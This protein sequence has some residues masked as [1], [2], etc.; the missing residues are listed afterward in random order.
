MHGIIQS[1][2]I[3]LLGSKMFLML[4]K[5]PVYRCEVLDGFYLRIGRVEMRASLFLFFSNQIFFFKIIKTQNFILLR[6]FSDSFYAT[7]SKYSSI[8]SIGKYS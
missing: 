5:N 1:R 3:S 2:V 6:R 7:R 4:E 8:V